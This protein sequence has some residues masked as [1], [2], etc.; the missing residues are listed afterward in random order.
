MMLITKPWGVIWG[1]HKG[2]GLGSPMCC[3]LK[4]YHL[5]RAGCF[6]KQPCR[7][8]Y[9]TEVR[10]GVCLR[11]AWNVWRVSTFKAHGKC[12][13]KGLSEKRMGPG[14]TH[15]QRMCLRLVWNQS[16][17]MWTCGNRP[18][19]TVLSIGRSMSSAREQWGRGVCR[20]DHF[21][22]TSWWTW[23]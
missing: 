1:K 22:E 8:C 12:Q 14:C 3:R 11:R 16:P 18:S 21:G 6:T 4:M 10:H 19:Q 5:R 9:C 20:F 15:A 7:P 13:A 23:I 17:T 2:A